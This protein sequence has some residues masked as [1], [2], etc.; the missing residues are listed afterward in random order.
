MSEVRLDDGQ[1]FEYDEV[2]VVHEDREPE[3]ETE[4]DEEQ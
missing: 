4:S 1:I 2:D 3:R